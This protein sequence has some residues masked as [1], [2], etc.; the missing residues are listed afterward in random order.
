MII[1][2]ADRCTACGLCEKICHEHCLHLVGGKPVIQTEFCSS[3]TQCVAVCPQRGLTWDHAMVTPF[4]R[5]RLPSAEQLDELFKERR[6]TRFFRKRNIDRPL[7]E[8]IVSYAIYAPTENFHLRAILIDDKAILAELE[9]ALMKM[10]RRIYKLAF[11]AAWIQRITPLLGLEFTYLRSKS[12]VEN[13]VQRS[14]AFNSPPPA[15]VF[16]VGE[17]RLP[18]SDASAQYALANIFY[19]AQVKGIGSCLCG[20]GPLIFDKNKAIRKRLGSERRE[21]IL[22]ALMLGYPAVR[23]SN[24]VHGKSLPIQWNAVEE[25]SH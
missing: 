2:D 1:I 23:Y 7:L 16:I 12:K 10:T 13:A 3:C 4:E 9:A 6:S 21:N 18:L 5:K 8:E 19:Y 14:H 15:M 11:R 22:G 20:N 17:K 25:K 24:K